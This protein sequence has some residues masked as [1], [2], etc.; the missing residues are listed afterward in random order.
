VRLPPEPSGRLILVRHAPAAGRNPRRWPDDKDRPLSPEGRS[1]FARSARGLARLLSERGEIL[2][3]PL[4]RARQTASLLHRAW[5]GSSSPHEV[6]SLDETSNAEELLA[7][8]NRRPWKDDRVLV[9]HE[10][11]LVGL[12]GLALVGDAVP[13]VELTRGGAIA[14]SFEGRAAPNR[15]RLLWALTRRQLRMLGR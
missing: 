6:P 8:L 4:A 15:G 5:K 12:V 13:L 11:Q 14:L 10:P 9:G 1:E 7:V 3:S 2:T